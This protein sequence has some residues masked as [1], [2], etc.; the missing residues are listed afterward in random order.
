M[1]GS[2]IRAKRLELGLTHAELRSKFDVTKLTVRQWAN[3][4][5]FPSETNLSHVIAWLSI[6]VRQTSEQRAGVMS[7]VDLIKTKR[8][9]LGIG[10]YEMAVILGVGKSR[11]Y[12]WESGR[13]VPSEESCEKIANWLSAIEAP[14]R[15]ASSVVSCWN[16][17][18]RVSE[19]RAS[20]LTGSAVKTCA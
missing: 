6:L 19:H 2:R 20:S 7:L 4:K 3:G 15:S 8:Q 5:T 1:L 10:V 13:S 18:G 11:I 9:N 14:D 17:A 16:L 12:D